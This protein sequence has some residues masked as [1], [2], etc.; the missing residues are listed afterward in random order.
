MTLA[1]LSISIA[2]AMVSGLVAYLRASP[3]F[4]GEKTP[5]GIKE[6]VGVMRR[7]LTFGDE[8]GGAL[9]RAKKLVWN[10]ACLN[11]GK[12]SLVGRQ[13]ACLLPENPGNPGN[14]GN[15]GIPGIPGG[16]PRGPSVEFRPGP[17]SPLCTT[18]CGKLCTGYYCV[19][20]PTGT[21]PDFLGNV[22]TTAPF[23]I[24]MPGPG[25]TGGPGE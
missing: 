13:A 14:S 20:N 8:V 4:S 16:A 23:P 24:I 5:T 18:N 15:P 22:V 3:D 12:R 10:G 17:P 1:N 6:A 19:P 11:G 25:E 2:T 7:P 21:P 9:G